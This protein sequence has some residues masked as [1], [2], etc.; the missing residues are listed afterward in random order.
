M[1]GPVYNCGLL[2]EREQALGTR[3]RRLAAVL[4]SSTLGLH[5]VLDTMK[6]QEEGFRRSQALRYQES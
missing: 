3:R 5:P 6:N 2:I 1:Y 4:N